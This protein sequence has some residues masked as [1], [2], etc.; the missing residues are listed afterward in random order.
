MAFQL[1]SDRKATENKT[2]RF[3]LDLIKIWM[4]PTKKIKS[5]DNDY[6]AGNP[7]SPG[8]FRR[9]SLFHAD[10]TA[11]PYFI[12]YRLEYATSRCRPLHSCDYTDKNVCYRYPFWCEH[13]DFHINSKQM[14]FCH[15]FQNLFCLSLI[16]WKKDLWKI[17]HHS[18]CCFFIYS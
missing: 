17:F 2:I 15:R 12:L 7:L 14:S 5:I 8:Q 1:K 16:P 11:S 13:S 9:L 18:F 3:P 10:A 6:F 4:H